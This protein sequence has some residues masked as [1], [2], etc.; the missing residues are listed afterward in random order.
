VVAALISWSRRQ[1]AVR[2]FPA[3]GALFLLASGV[4]LVNG[5]PSLMA[6]L[7]TSQPLQLQL[8]VLLASG[9]VGILLQ[10]A[11]MGL[12]SGAVPVW[13]R[14]G[15][16]ERRL[17]LRAAIALG[18]AAGAARILSTLPGGDRPWPSY[19]GAAA[20]VPFLAAAVDPI[21]VLLARVVFLTLVVAAANQL[22][23][24]WTRQ[25]LPVGVLL[26]LVGGVLGNAGSPR[27]LLVWIGVSVAIGLLF[28]V[29]YV[30]VLRH[31]VSVVPVAAAVMTS[32]GA[33]REGLAAAYPGSLPGAIVSVVAMLSLG[34]LWSRALAIH[35]PAPTASPVAVLP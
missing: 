13:C 22:S 12:V 19:D 5:F 34:V 32:L 30:A 3:V 15:A 28:L 10:S 23:G 11:A 8:F 6:A 24:I 4:R 31:D 27:D 18:A 26:V 16:V 17:A 9:T 33:L 29:A 21:G 1:F 20:L 35:A 2:F 7:S 14:G 25:R